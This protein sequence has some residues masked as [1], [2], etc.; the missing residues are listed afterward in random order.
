MF[1]SSQVHSSLS[2]KSISLKILLQYDLAKKLT[3]INVT[4]YMKRVTGISDLKMKFYL[5][6]QVNNG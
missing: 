1:Y 5:P 6:I 3:L 2:R 4:V